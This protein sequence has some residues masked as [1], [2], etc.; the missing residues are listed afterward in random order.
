M[1]GTWLLPARDRLRRLALDG[2]ARCSRARGPLWPRAVPRRRSAAARSDRILDRPSA[3]RASTGLPTTASP[4]RVRDQPRRQR[5]ASRSSG[6]ARDISLAL[7]L[8]AGGEPRVRCPE[9][10]GFAR[11][12]ACSKSAPMRSDCARRAAYFTTRRCGFFTATSA[13]SSPAAVQAA[14]SRPG[15]SCPG[16][17]PARRSRARAAIG[18]LDGLADSGEAR[19]ESARGPCRARAARRRA[20][21]C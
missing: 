9:S 6:I 13:S 4:L 17:F 20:R 7:E 1:L 15:T 21:R 10:S 19:D 18:N 16:R 8:A 11:S 14:R 12:I 2:C 3:S 5:S